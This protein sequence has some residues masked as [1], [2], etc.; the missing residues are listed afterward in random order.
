MT[1][2]QYR[3]ICVRNSPADPIT[4]SQDQ[5]LKL[6]CALGIGGEGGEVEDILKKHVFHGKPLDSV[7]LLEEIGDVLWYV[8]RLLWLMG[9]T[10]HDA[11]SINAAKI[12]ARYPNG[13]KPQFNDDDGDGVLH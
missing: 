2:E 3:E 11:M 13:F 9:H 7:R 1:P 5:A 4:I 12:L 8:D 6:L 10:L